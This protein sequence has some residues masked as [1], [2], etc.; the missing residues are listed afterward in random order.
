MEWNADG[1]AWE[2][3]MP[4]ARKRQTNRS[5]VGVGW[6]GGCRLR[7]GIRGGDVSRTMICHRHP[8]TAIDGLQQE[9]CGL[10]TLQGLRQHLRRVG[11]TGGKA[12]TACSLHVRAIDNGC[13]QGMRHARR[14][15]VAMGR[16]VSPE[17]LPGGTWASGKG[18]TTFG[19]CE[20]LHGV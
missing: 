16:A 14:R 13:L 3:G 6:A 18:H 7:S 2:A 11:V 9:R 19:V 10:K 1:L 17:A 12:E 5:W 4:S 20:C 15:R 8:S